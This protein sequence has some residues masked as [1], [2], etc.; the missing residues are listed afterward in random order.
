VSFPNT[1]LGT[2]WILGLDLRSHSLGAANFASWLARTSQVAGGERVVAV[3]VLE[4]AHLRAALRYHH[5]A[6]VKQSARGLAESRLNGIDFGR[7]ID[8]EL[9]EGGTAEERLEAARLYH[10]AAGLIIGRYATREGHHL[11]RL[12]RVARR[13]LRALAAPTLVVP[14]DY[15]ADQSDGPI[16]VAVD[17][18]DDCRHGA[19]F[20]REMGTRL[21]RKIVLVHVVATPDDYGAYYLPEA[22]LE[23]LRVEQQ[24]HG[25]HGLDEWAQQHGFSDADQVVLQGGV[26]EQ[27]IKFA[28]QSRACLVVSGSRRLTPFER[29]FL[30][31]VGSELAAVSPVPVAVVP[32][33]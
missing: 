11:L 9:I 30:T 14:P 12:G 21:D 31:S 33:S 8:I 6:E 32:P 4:E 24:E 15:D 5:L 2:R 17:L 13:L 25:K 26:I 27:I 19:R 28:G 16:V 29:F 7:P 10:N 3:H 22:S 18:D 23:K 20:A 1:H